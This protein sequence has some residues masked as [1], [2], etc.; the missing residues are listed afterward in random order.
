M[1]TFIDTGILT[2]MTSQIL[3]LTGHGLYESKNWIRI[4]MKLSVTVDDIVTETEKNK[5]EKKKKKV[6]NSSKH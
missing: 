2:K 4:K 6:T 3:K 1:H 5:Q